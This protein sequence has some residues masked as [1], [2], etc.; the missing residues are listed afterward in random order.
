MFFAFSAVQIGLASS[1]FSRD[2]SH[3][4]RATNK[5]SLWKT[6]LA[7]YTTPPIGGSQTSFNPRQSVSKTVNFG[8]F[9]RIFSHFSFIFGHIAQQSLRRQGP[10]SLY[11]AFYLLFAPWRLCG[12]QYF[13]SVALGL[14]SK[15]AQMVDQMRR[16]LQTKI[17]FF[18][19]FYLLTT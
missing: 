6:G 8:H 17:N 3:E 12:I 11:E 19:N 15:K 18:E 4:I 10:R 16:G 14:R 7:E 13:P 5:C 9:S 1:V 2:T